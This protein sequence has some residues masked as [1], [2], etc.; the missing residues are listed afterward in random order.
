M[1]LAI[2]SCP[3]CGSI[4]GTAGR[5]TGE[6]CT[7]DSNVTRGFYRHWKGALYYVHGVSRNDGTGE[8]VVVYASVQGNDDGLL[9]HRSASEFVEVFEHVPAGTSGI[10]RLV[11]RFTRVPGAA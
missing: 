3:L 1:G 6:R 9:R 11:Q 8:L 5:C 2:A 7:F 10:T 4:I